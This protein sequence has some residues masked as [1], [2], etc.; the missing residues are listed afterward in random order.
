MLSIF[1]YILKIGACQEL[2]RFVPESFDFQ[3]SESGFTGFKDW[4]DYS[5]ISDLLNH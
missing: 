4:Q 2:P 5:G 3:F 1:K